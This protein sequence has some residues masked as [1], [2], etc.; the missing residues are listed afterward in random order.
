M[1][2]Q[3]E[4]R[5]LK[6]VDVDSFG[7]SVPFVRLTA[8]SGETRTS[9]TGLAEKDQTKY[10]F[11]VDAIDN[12]LTFGADKNPAKFAV[13]VLT[14]DTSSGQIIQYPG[15][16]TINIFLDDANNNV[17]DA[18]CPLCEDGDEM[19]E[20]GALIYSYTV[21]EANTSA[22]ADEQL[23][24]T[25]FNTASLEPSPRVDIAAAESA[26]AVPASEASK[27]KDTESFRD[28]MDAFDRAMMKEENMDEF[29]NDQAAEEDLFD[30]NSLGPNEELIV[31]PELHIHPE[32]AH[33]DHRHDHEA[34]AVDKISI[35]T[36]N[37][38]HEVTLLPPQAATKP[39]DMREWMHVAEC[40]AENLAIPDIIRADLANMGPQCNKIIVRLH[41]VI[42]SSHH[43]L[44]TTTATAKLSIQPLPDNV[45]SLRSVSNK[46]SKANE[47]INQTFG[48]SSPQPITSNTS[49]KKSTSHSTA[50]SFGLKTAQLTLGPG[51]LRSKTYREGACPR[52]CLEIALGGSEPYTGFAELYLPTLLLEEECR[53]QVLSVPLVQT[54]RNDGDHT[55]A[56]TSS[57]L[58]FE[59]NPPDLMAAGSYNA[60][61]DTYTPRSTT[62]PNLNRAA[63]TAAPNT[64]RGVTSTAAV[65][66][67]TKKRPTKASR[68]QAAGKE[69]KVKGGLI[70]N[71]PC[72]MD[73]E[74]E[75]SGVCGAA[76]E[77]F[78][79]LG[80]T[81]R[82]EAYLT[83]SGCTETVSLCNLATKQNSADAWSIKKTF[84][85]H[86]NRP[87]VDILQ[88]RLRNGPFPED[89]IGRFCVPLAALLQT[90]SEE[91]VLNKALPFHAWKF[92]H[93]DKGTS[94]LSAKWKAVG[95]LR[96]QSAGPSP[97]QRT[98]GASTM[99]DTT[100]GQSIEFGTCTGTGTGTGG[101]F[102][103]GQFSPDRTSAYPTISG[104]NI[105]SST[106]S[107]GGNNNN[108]N[109]W[110][111]SPSRR[112]PAGKYDSSAM[113]TTSSAVASS[114]KPTLVKSI[115]GQ[116]V[117]CVKGYFSARSVLDATGNQDFHEREG[118][119][120]LSRNQSL[121][122]ETTLLPEGLRKRTP[123]ATATALQSGDIEA[124]AAWGKS[125]SMF[126]AYATQQV[127]I[128]FFFFALFWY[129]CYFLFF[130]FFSCWE[131]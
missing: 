85:L 5:I 47:D 39:V 103:G 110:M 96:Y 92:C 15:V 91:L 65:G 118:P 44:E 89:E 41:S 38:V 50:F 112:S 59:L 29:L 2:K 24:E 129:S 26:H 122:V 74:L 1:S 30:I 8:P 97:S 107:F 90:S 55:C 36:P 102:D 128:V 62:N 37:E 34:A 125:F 60:T 93:S 126:L 51:D 6:L 123:S 117:V 33:L 77:V 119:L 98:I 69:E 76:L 22:A 17:S 94:Y 83:A 9:G 61:G 46:H 81:A 124:T 120:F 104:A 115:S 20:I 113:G 66:A 53:G 116:L 67:S 42:V 18:H 3:I 79:N 70:P 54:C 127:R 114:A 84:F 71:I 35:A 130:I 88:L 108:N 58:L 72:A 16:G 87:K 99:L 95:V 101:E 80:A 111:T 106:R 21:N 56:T 11:S 52:L 43:V 4:I 23:D 121:C 14:K 109:N 10:T 64:A 78:P 131:I 63:T 100:G 73:V 28:D 32:H 48:T 49:G 25:D 19:L 40:S 12:V 75:L 57:T 7:S 31:A 68:S 82:L 86:S 13:A 27:V 105:T 45:V